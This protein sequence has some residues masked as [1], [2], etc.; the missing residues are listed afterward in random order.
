[1]SKQFTRRDF[2]RFTGQSLMV[3]GVASTFGGLGMR[4]AQAADLSELTFQAS[5]INDAEF[6]GYFVAM[7]QGYYKNSGIKMN[8]LSGGADVIPESAL[9]SGKADITLTTPDTTVQA[10]VEQGAPFK[11]IGQQYQ[12]NPIGIVSLEENPVR[13]P[14]DLI[15]K[16]L[17]VPAVN[18]ISVA[19]MLKL[20]GIKDGQVRLV[21]Y[22]GDPT[23]LIKGEVDAVVNFVTGV[24]NVIEKQGKKAVSFLLYDFGLTIP[25]DTVVVLEETLNNRRE[26]LIK[27]LRA[28]RQGWD[29][30][31]KDP[32]KYPAEF[33]DSWFKGTG[34]ETELDIFQNT[35]QLPL[36]Q[37]PEGYFAM[38]EESIAATIEGL[39]RVG[40]QATRDM[41]DTTLLAEV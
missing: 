35:A 40:I 30:N 14:K 24:P 34:R 26:D 37:S 28:S 22:Q 7:Q 17:A 32:A 36:M 20:A 23:P 18:N 11:I 15:G 38:T 12:R 1:M 3:A 21:P 9:L 13:E 10:I 27:W 8:Y 29:E 19:A 5:W 39:S 2:I 31:A 25:N 6:I 4:S 41:F 33:A 16:V